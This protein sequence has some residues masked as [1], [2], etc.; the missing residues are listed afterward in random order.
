MNMRAYF[1]LQDN[2]QGNMKTISLGQLPPPSPPHPTSPQPPPQKEK[3]KKTKTNKKSTNY[4]KTNAVKTEDLLAKYE[5][6][7]CDSVTPPLSYPSPPPPPKKK[8]QKKKKNT[9]TQ[10]PPTYYFTPKTNA[11]KTERTFEGNMK[12]FPVS[13]L[14]PPFPPHP[15]HPPQKKKEKQQH[16]HVISHPKLMQLK[17]RGPLREI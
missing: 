8:N 3:K 5:T 17:W 15:T 14:P 10:N 13:Q 1:S 16:R 7:F 11:V 9:H 6:L 12:P 2:A 4:F